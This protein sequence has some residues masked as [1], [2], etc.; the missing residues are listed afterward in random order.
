[1]GVPFVELEGAY[2]GAM[3]P[4]AFFIPVEGDLVG[5]KLTLRFQPARTDFDGVEARGIYV[6]A[7]LRTMGLPIVLTVP[8]P[9]KGGHFVITRAADARDRPVEMTVR[10]PPRSNTMV[11]ES[12]FVRD[13]VKG[14]GNVASYRMSLKA[15]N[16]GC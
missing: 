2:I 8:F 6:I 5:Q 15:C 13:K 9:Y 14:D 7:G 10:I 1:M 16:P 11:A 4:R 12:T 3:G